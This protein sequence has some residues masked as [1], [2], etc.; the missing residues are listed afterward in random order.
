MDDIYKQTDRKSLEKFY[1][2]PI[3]DEAIVETI[4]ALLGMSMLHINSLTRGGFSELEDIMEE[5]D[6]MIYYT[7]QQKIQYD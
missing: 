5:P 4:T 7:I 2:V 3:P 1:S 6:W